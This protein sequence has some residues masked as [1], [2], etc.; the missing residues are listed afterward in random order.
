MHFL[1]W[2]YCGIRG[3]DDLSLGTLHHSKLRELV[4]ETAGLTS[5]VLRQVCCS[6]LPSLRHLEVWLGTAEFGRFDITDLQP[7]LS[8]RLFPE[9]NY[10]GLRNSDLANEIAAVAVHA[11]IVQR[12]EILDLSL[13]NLADSG[14]R[15]LLRLPTDARLRQLD[16]H[17][18]RVSEEVIEQLR[19]CLPFPIDARDR[20]ESGGVA[21][22]PI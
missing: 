3:S 9:L 21:L 8:G 11:P 7:I 1:V 10:L 22:W 2:R 6:N 14:A 17:H 20:R 12:I 4:V 5:N 13:G 15:A 19:S 18:H 16:I